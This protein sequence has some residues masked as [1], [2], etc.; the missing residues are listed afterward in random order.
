MS[1]IRVLLGADDN[2]ALPA[3]VT[4]RSLLD[5]HRRRDDLE[6]IVL[7]GG[8]TER[9]KALILD[10][11]EGL[12]SF[13]SPQSVDSYPTAT[14]PLTGQPLSRAMYLRLQIPMLLADAPRAIYLDSDVVVRDD[15][16]ALWEM[17]LG[18]GS[19]VGAVLCFLTPRGHLGLHQ[20]GFGEESRNFNSGVLLMDLVSLRTS[21]ERV[22]DLARGGNLVLPDQDA[23]NLV[24]E[25]DW[26]P[27]PPRWN[28][29]VH[30]QFRFFGERGAPWKLGGFFK[31][32]EISEMRTNPAIVHF[33]SPL[34]PWHLDGSSLEHA[35]AWL[36]VASRTAFRDDLSE[37]RERTTLA[38]TMNAV[39]REV[40]V[41]GASVDDS[42]VNEFLTAAHRRPR[43][44]RQP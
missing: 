25:N 31:T 34:K 18:Q 13:V 26:T 8:L 3:A 38:R 30:G 11:S 29:Q 4:I 43:T 24:Y 16:A 22:I 23:L 32:E 14:L 6:I 15:V 35:D 27:L 41:L 12:T 2:Y 19:P 42:T 5:H 44:R 9:S 39:K 7:D 28:Y 17:P 1:P 20:R 33:A 40:A 21:I 37:F 36:S 10:S